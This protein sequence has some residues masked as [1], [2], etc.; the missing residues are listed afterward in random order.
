[1]YVT[2]G[3]RNM[4]DFFRVEG[5]RGVATRRRLKIGAGGWLSCRRVREAAAASKRSE[6]AR[7]KQ[8]GKEKRREKGRGVGVDRERVEEGRR[9]T[10][11]DGFFQSSNLL[12]LFF[13][14]NVAAVS[15]LLIAIR[16]G[17]GFAGVGFRGGM[18]ARTFRYMG[19]G[20]EGRA[21]R[22]ERC[23]RSFRSVSFRLVPVSVRYVTFARPC[24]S[25]RNIGAE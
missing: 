19:E 18:R 1:M 15:K 23:C 20:G 13:P 25:S 10:A 4:V 7:E 21:D 11:G 3:P 2:L 8:G 14:R 5:E 22:Y 6:S 12:N 9:G 24:I 16:E 17:T